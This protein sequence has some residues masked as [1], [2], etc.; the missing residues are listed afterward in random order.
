MSE[1]INK[2]AASGLVTIDLESM[3]PAGQR[4]VIDIREQLWMELALKEKDF[5][6][7]IKTN[8]WERYRGHFVAVTCSNDAIIPNWA[9]MLVASALSGVARKVVFGSVDQL[10][11]AIFS[12]LIAAL[13]GEEY[14]DKRL[15]IKGCS[16]LPVPVSAY[17][18]IV[19]KL[20]PVA[21][22]I[23]FGEPCSTV[24]VFKRT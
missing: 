19:A 10:E 3:Y 1:I 20:Q 6:E 15:V 24:P 21:K 7:W 11:T 22:S 14:A 13:P 4:S 5:R 12:E 23:M 17:V 16:D 9:Y 8:D 18:E 2:V